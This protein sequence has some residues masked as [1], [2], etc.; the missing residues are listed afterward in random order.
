MAEAEEGDGGALPNMT[1]KPKFRVIARARLKKMVVVEVGGGYQEVDLGP[2]VRE[3]NHIDSPSWLQDIPLPRRLAELA[4]DPRDADFGLRWEQLA[5]ETMKLSGFNR[6]SNCHLNSAPDDDA[7]AFQWDIKLTRELAP[8]ADVEDPST[9][10]NKYKKAMSI[11]DTLWL[12]LKDAAGV[13]VDLDNMLGD[14]WFSYSTASVVTTLFEAITGGADQPV[15]ARAVRQPVAVPVN[16]RPARR[17]AAEQA[18]AE[19]Q[20]GAAPGV[21]LPREAG[22]GESGGEEAMEEEEG[23]ESGSASGA[24]GASG[25]EEKE[26]E[27]EGGYE[28]GGG[29]PDLFDEENETCP[30]GKE[31]LFF[32]T[33]RCR[34][35]GKMMWSTEL[36]RA[37]AN[38]TPLPCGLNMPTWLAPRWTQYPVILTDHEPLRVD[39]T[40]VGEQFTFQFFNTV[41]AANQ[42]TAA[43][44]VARAAPA[45]PPR[46]PSEDE[47]SEGEEEEEETEEEEGA[48]AAPGPPPA[49]AA[50]AAPGFTPAAAASERPPAAAA[51]EEESSKGEEEESSEGV[52]E[53]GRMEVQEVPPPPLTAYPERYYFYNVPGDGGCF[54]YAFY[55]GERFNATGTVVK[56]PHILTGMSKQEQDKIQKEHREIVTRYKSAM[57]TYIQDQRNITP[58]LEAAIV[59]SFEGASERL[60]QDKEFNHRLNPTDADDKQTYWT[61]L[62]LEQREAA[63]DRARR[64]INQDKKNNPNE[65][66]FWE[67]WQYADS[68]EILT[69]T[70][71]NDVTLVIFHC[72]TYDKFQALVQL[73]HDQGEQVLIDQL[74]NVAKTGENPT[75]LPDNTLRTNRHTIYVLRQRGGGSEHYAALLPLPLAAAAPAAPKVSTGGPAMAAAAAAAAPDAPEVSMGEPAVAAAAAA[76]AVPP[77]PEVSTEGPAVAAALPPGIPPFVYVQ[78]PPGS[79]PVVT[80]VPDT[81]QKGFM[82]GAAPPTVHAALNPSPDVVR[83]FGA[84]QAKHLTTGSRGKIKKSLRPAVVQVK[85]TQTGRRKP[86]KLGAKEMTVEESEEAGVEEESEEAGVEEEKET[87][88]RREEAVAA[89][90]PEPPPPQSPRRSERQLRARVL[91]E[92]EAQLYLLWMLSL[93]EQDRPPI[94]QDI[95]SNFQERGFRKGVMD[96]SQ[97]QR[98]GL[99]ENYGN[100]QQLLA[101]TTISRDVQQQVKDS[102]EREGFVYQSYLVLPE[103]ERLGLKRARNERL[104]TE[105]ETR[106]KGV[107]GMVN[108]TWPPEKPFLTFDA[109]TPAATGKPKPSNIP[110]Q[111]SMFWIKP[112]A[113]LQQEL[114]DRSENVLK[115]INESPLFKKD[116]VGNPI[117]P[118]ERTQL[119]KQKGDVNK[120]RR[121]YIV[122]AHQFLS[123]CKKSKETPRMEA[124]LSAWPGP[125]QQFRSGTFDLLK[126]GATG[127]TPTLAREVQESAFWGQFDTLYTGLLVPRVKEDVF[128]PAMWSFVKRRKSRIKGLSKDQVNELWSD[129]KTYFFKKRRMAFVY[130]PSLK[131]GWIASSFDFDASYLALATIC[132]SSTLQVM[133]NETLGLLCQQ[134]GVTFEKGRRDATVKAVATSMLKQYFGEST[135]LGLAPTVQL[136]AAFE[137]AIAASRPLLHQFMRFMPAGTITAYNHQVAQ[138]LTLRLGYGNTKLLEL[139]TLSTKTKDLKLL[140]ASFCYLYKQLGYEYVLV[141]GVPNK[142]L[143]RFDPA[144]NRCKDM[145]FIEFAQVKLQAHPLTIVGGKLVASSTKWVD[146]FTYYALQ[147]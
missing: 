107:E 45:A 26:G 8:Q 85:I 73:A 70:K 20:P 108:W 111:D 53:G 23:E 31:D 142:A 43:E 59:A 60:A 65:K 79:R 140:W 54:Y 61:S 66:D 97:K 5:R 77:A 119:A 141:S 78:P 21:P 117:A 58:E 127:A 102:M 9:T 120:L 135:V 64:M 81:T 1:L 32:V 114:K 130:L 13:P 96:L 56:V 122:A 136:D 93:N 15:A 132:T 116:F 103:K 147:I 46:E 129:T 69:L 18:A 113:T 27:E 37:L 145:P 71:V 133:E 40:P 24:S 139:W 144:T 34:Q 50:A 74:L 38:D 7:A 87:E 76:A 118:H 68:L 75:I 121:K 72:E 91:T 105:K 39:R 28:G 10:A 33:A 4:G 80:F 90:A 126:G 83:Q 63:L 82:F 44:R 62:S 100:I 99:N 112:C 138:N 146:Y 110:Q 11:L 95:V 134:L 123:Y 128:P 17:G 6:D 124:K 92:G 52:E 125:P 35:V 131:A 2:P 67:H 19:A 22:E 104:Q 48:A 89:E 3:D 57:W 36:L 86:V 55:M 84:A 94:V 115:K 12:K 98:Q 101:R 137:S 42:Y 25:E 14:D 51:A 30:R 41:D 109:E 29:G 49:A 106:L 88:T 16:V 47:S 143:H